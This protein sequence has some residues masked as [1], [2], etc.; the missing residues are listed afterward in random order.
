MKEWDVVAEAIKNELVPKLSNKYDELCA[1]AKKDVEAGE[2]DALW[3]ELDRLIVR[4]TF[5]NNKQSN[6]SNHFIKQAKEELDSFI[7]EIR[8]SKIEQA[9][10]DYGISRG[11][12][13]IKD[14]LTALI[15]AKVACLSDS[16]TF[17][18]A[19]DI[20]INSIDL[21]DFFTVE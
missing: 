18:E 9:R 4:A 7:N 2:Y 20:V 15:E 11:Y 21:N 8:D 1:A 13:M 12:W 16:V 3:P 10:H 6:I 19:R 14:N 17:E 5:I